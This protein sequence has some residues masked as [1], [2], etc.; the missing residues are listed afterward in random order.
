MAEDIKVKVGGDITG[1]D[2]ALKRG[3]AEV[4][5]F[6]TA[7]SQSFN[8]LKSTIFGL[9]GAMLGLVG[10]FTVKK[11]IS[12]A[13]E[14][15]S[16]VTDMAKVTNQ[17]FSQIREQIE[18]LGPELGSSTDLVKGYYQTISAGV[19]DPKKALDLVV[20]AS[21]AAKAAHMGQSDVIKVLT[22]MMAGYGGELKSVSDAADLLFQIEKE[23]QTT[24]QE[25]VPLMGS[26]SNLARVAGLKYQEMAG[27]LALITQTAGSTAEAT[28]Q[29]EALMV[30][31]VKPT[32]QMITL[33]KEWGGIGPAMKKL[34]FVQ[35]LKEIEKA[36]G[37][38][39]DKLAELVGGRKE[40]LIGYLGL[41]ANNFENLTGKIESMNNSAGA[42]DR[43]WE[44]F[45]KTW[46]GISDTF[47]NLIKNIFIQ[48]GGSIL[49]TISAEVKNISAEMQSWLA[50]NKQFIEQDLPGKV[51]SGFGTMK[52]TVGFF[53]DLVKDIDK[54]TM[55]A[56]L[57][58][59]S[60]FGKLGIM[61]VLAYSSLIRTALENMYPADVFTADMQN[62]Q[63]EADEIKR[64]IAGRGTEGKFGQALVE[65]LAFL[66]SR[67]KTF[68]GTLKMDA[69]RTAPQ[70]LWGP[71]GYGQPPAPSAVA[72]PKVVP[73]SFDF[74]SIEEE[75]QKLSKVL[76]AEDDAIRDHAQ[77][78]W[79]DREQF[80]KQAVDRSKQL[81]LSG[82]DY[83]LW[84]LE[85]EK[86]QELLKFGWNEGLRKLIEDNYKKSVDKIRLEGNRST[87]AWLDNQL[88]QMQGQGATL[89]ELSDAERDW[90][91]QNSQ[92]AWDGVKFAMTDFGDKYKTEAQRWYETTLT[93][94]NSI[95]D[96]FTNA[97][98]SVIDGTKS[99]KEA[100][101]DMARSIIMDLIKIQVQQSITSAIG[102][103]GIGGKAGSGLLGM[104]F[105][106][107]P[108]SGGIVGTTS[109][110]QYAVPSSTFANAPRLHK[111]LQNDEY[112]AIL[113]RGETVL[114]RGKSQGG[115]PTFIIHMENPVFQDL[116]TQNAVFQ[117]IAS[118]MVYSLAPGA[119]IQSYRNDEEIRGIIRSRT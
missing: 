14:Y 72:P 113:Q 118:K 95:R 21:K 29:L 88:K 62:M 91:L 1:L 22:K 98:M 10:A 56:G 25:L 100:F 57:I 55:G 2:R 66:E 69:E 24:F 51:E 47:N 116:E 93:V 115:Q 74:S 102:S 85:E 80:Q 32:E 27:G 52:S 43:A 46:E 5:S 71:E 16:A 37:G 78:M 28:T 87:R 60:M 107:K 13:A 39:A 7:S 94:A 117:S 9:Q 112:P 34:G 41:M 3:A 11:V 110:P 114:P 19:T 49:P 68:K 76:D 99:A 101:R 35:F 92:K 17:S 96:N 73:P 45:E 86:N 18:S 104:I 65:R 105:P 23:G 42:A 75:M 59:Y 61:A 38:S 108:H 82:L 33:F 54:W 109:F 77:K 63:K 81:T 90:T 111:G 106:G 64:T 58:A 40:A 70:F 48:L 44:H 30:A 31:L 89:K 15:Q 103:V 12:S 84:A 4:R 83:K 6:S 97:F 53:W 50:V 79:D 20:T 8:R 36:A 67:L 119:I 26:I